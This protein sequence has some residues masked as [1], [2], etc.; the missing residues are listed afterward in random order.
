[1]E[2]LIYSVIHV[3]IDL[4]VNTFSEF[5]ICCQLAWIGE[6]WRTVV[7]AKPEAMEQ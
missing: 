4:V 5:G 3:W 2:G 7:I 1:M 6:R